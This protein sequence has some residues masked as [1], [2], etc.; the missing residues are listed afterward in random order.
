MSMSHKAFALVLK[1]IREA[2]K[3]GIDAWINPS[4]ET[5]H[6]LIISGEN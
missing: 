4:G 6:S 3:S 5:R 2:R 1:L